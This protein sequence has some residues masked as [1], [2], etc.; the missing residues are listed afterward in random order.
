MEK[1]FKCMRTLP[2]DY[3]EYGGDIKRWADPEL[4]YPDCSCGCRHFIPLEGELGGDWG[5]CS[6]PDAPRKG[7]LTWEHQA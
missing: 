6:N 2:S 4:A 5:V 7:L 1:L 3:E